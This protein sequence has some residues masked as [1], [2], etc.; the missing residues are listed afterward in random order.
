MKTGSFYISRSVFT[1]AENYS[2]HLWILDFINII[3]L[4]IVYTM[5]IL[6][7]F[8][9]FDIFFYFNNNNIVKWLLYT[10]QFFLLKPIFDYILVN[11][12]PKKTKLYRTVVK[13]I[14][15]LGTIVHVRY[16]VLVR[17]CVQYVNFSIFC[18][19]SQLCLVY[20][21]FKPPEL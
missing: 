17:F 8:Y 12:W 1:S 6:R 9:I 11:V 13:N 7:P 16:I 14:Q 21:V 5:T 2:G 19:R 15:D 4:F 3:Q 20:F 10:Y 18:S